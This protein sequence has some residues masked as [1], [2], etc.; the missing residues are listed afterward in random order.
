MKTMASSEV[1]GRERK[2]L[3]LLAFDI[4]GTTIKHGVVTAKGD[5]LQ[6]GIDVTPASMALLFELLQ[7]IKHRY[8][9]NYTLSGAAFSTPGIPN[10]ATGFIDGG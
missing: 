9:A 4:G 3:N 7:D 1:V 10:Q 2:H 5:I 6:K 8:A